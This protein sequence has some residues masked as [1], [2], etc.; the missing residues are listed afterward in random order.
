MNGSKKVKEK[1]KR[2][3]PKLVVHRLENISK[4]IFKEYYGIITEL[5]GSSHG[6]YALYDETELYY[7]GK[8]ADLRKRVRH[9]LRDRHLASWT[10][11]SLYLV[12]KADYIHEIESLLINIANPKGNR[13][14]PK[15]KS[16]TMIKKL[17]NMIK[18]EQKRKLDELLGSKKPEHKKRKRR[19][20]IKEKD[21]RQLVSK[22][23][24]LYRTY[25]GKE[26]KAVLTPAGSIRMG[27]KGYSTPTA[28][29]KA[30]VD[31]KAVNGWKFW[32]IKDLNGDWVRLS[33]YKG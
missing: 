2:K 18:E 19:Y 11:F 15:G 25:K 4:A 26:Y 29:A 10:H 24:R 13:M 20:T 30:I 6:I 7:V 8:S 33:D 17:R 9:H 31:R 1:R 21:L 23:T 22:R 28:A 14:L 12:R 32:Y 5:I 3:S 16:K 27:G